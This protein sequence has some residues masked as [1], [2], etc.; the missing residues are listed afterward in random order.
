MDIQKHIENLTKQLLQYNYEYYNLNQSSISDAEYDALMRELINLENLY[1]QFK[2]ENSPTS[3]VGGNVSN[4]FKKIRHQ[5]P[6]LSLSNVYNTEDIQGFI[7]RIKDQIGKTPFRLDLE[8]KIDG[9]SISLRYKNGIL[10]QAS[11]RGDGQ[12]GEDITENAY[13]IKSIPKTIPLEEEIEVRGEVYMSIASFLKL[14]ANKEKNNEEPFANPRNAASGS[15]RQLDASITK[16]RDLDCFIYTLVQPSLYQIQTQEEALHFMK[17]L[18]FVINPETKIVSSLEEISEF[19]AQIGEK[20]EKLPY[21]ID[22]VVMKVNELSLY[23]A[24]GYTAK[25]PK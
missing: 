8:C 10:V 9:L 24:I 17:S 23:D 1:P 6:M 11:T 13:M 7:K 5:T 3:H 16:E 4:D 14:N 20:R 12:V 22:G 21:E 2:L 19:I 15:L 25:A 18:G